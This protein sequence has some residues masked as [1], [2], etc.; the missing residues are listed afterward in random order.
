V[1]EREAL[2][3]LLS[4]GL[5]DLRDRHAGSLV[6]FVK[7][8][9]AIE[10]EALAVGTREEQLLAEIDKLKASLREE[11][12]KH[13]AE[14]ETKNASVA[15]LKQQLRRLK[16]DTTLSL[17]YAR[18]ETAAQAENATLSL[19]AEERAVLGMIEE[20]RKKLDAELG[21]HEQTMDVLK[22]GE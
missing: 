12:E 21:A 19:S 16:V 6:D 14:M 22:H 11:S 7:R 13:A 4:H 1:H 3:V 9:H 8:E 20:L 10:E 5:D 17:R 15:A 18:K 2:T